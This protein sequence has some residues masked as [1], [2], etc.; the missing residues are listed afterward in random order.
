MKSVFLIATFCKTHAC[1]VSLRQYFFSPMAHQIVDHF[2]LI[3]FLRLIMKRQT[4]GQA[5]RLLLDL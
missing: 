5:V 2:G 4:A 1:P 3:P